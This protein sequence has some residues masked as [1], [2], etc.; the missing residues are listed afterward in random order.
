MDNQKWLNSLALVAGM[1]LGPYAL[2]YLREDFL[3][4]D[5][6]NV[7]YA[8]FACLVGALISIGIN[9]VR[10]Q[11]DFGIFVYQSVSTLAFAVLG[12]GITAILMAALINDFNPASSLL[13]ATGVGLFLGIF[14]SRLFLTARF[15]RAT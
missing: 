14:A 8:F 5:W 7:F 11:P 9:I 4:L 13:F 6:W 12:T 15:G 3:G 2:L 10:D 1:V